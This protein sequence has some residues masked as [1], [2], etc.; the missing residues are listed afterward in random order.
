[1]IE[2]VIEKLLRETEI[3]VSAQLK[4]GGGIRKKTLRLLS[5][6]I[7]TIVFIFVII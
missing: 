3:G 7:T 5:I 1:M 4:I 2:D 6:A